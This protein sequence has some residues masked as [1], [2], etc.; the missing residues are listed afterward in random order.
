MPCLPA[1]RAGGADHADDQARRLG[2]ILGGAYFKPAGVAEMEAVIG[3]ALYVL[4]LAVG[5]PVA[6]ARSA[7][8]ARLIPP[9]LS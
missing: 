9:R 3:I 5:G 1:R 2:A 4:V 8:L 7:W 6:A